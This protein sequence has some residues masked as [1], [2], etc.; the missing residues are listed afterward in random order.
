MTESEI[1]QLLK[2][3][4][5]LVTN[6]GLKAPSKEVIHFSSQFRCDPDLQALFPGVFC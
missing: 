4:V 2:D 1:V 6:K 5:I 3:N